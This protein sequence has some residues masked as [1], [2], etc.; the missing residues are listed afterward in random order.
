MPAPSARFFAE[1]GTATV[2]ET[3]VVPVLGLGRF[4]YKQRVVA[5]RAPWFANGVFEL[6]LLDHSTC[7]VEGAVRHAARRGSL[8]SCQFGRRR[9]QVQQGGP[10]LG[11]LH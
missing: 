8:N 5:P 4:A 10:V 1:T 3:V 11:P 7:P 6:E 2:F 9:S